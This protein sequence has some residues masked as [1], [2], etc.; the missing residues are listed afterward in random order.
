MKIEKFT[1]KE[2]LA[3]PQ[4]KP[5]QKKNYSSLNGIMGFNISHHTF[6]NPIFNEP[7]FMVFMVFGVIILS[8][9]IEYLLRAHGKERKADTVDTLTKTFIPLSFFIFLYFGIVKTF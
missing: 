5:Y 2:F 1:I 8:A 4:N 3:L 6:F 9:L 7:Y